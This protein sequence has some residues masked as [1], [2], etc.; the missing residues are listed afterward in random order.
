[1][2]L[3]R[4][5]CAFMAVLCLPVAALDYELGAELS[6]DHSGQENPGILGVSLAGALAGER[7]AGEAVSYWAR[8]LCRGGYSGTGASIGG[9]LEGELSLRK[10]FNVLRLG[11]YGQAAF[12]GT[13]FTWEAEPRLALSMGG[14]SWSAYNEHSF[15]LNSLADGAESYRTELGTALAFPAF[16][17]K[18]A[19]TLALEDLG[20]EPLLKAGARASLSGLA[21]GAL[22]VDIDLGAD[23]T[24]SRGSWSADAGTV[25]SGYLKRSLDWTLETAAWYDSFTAS[26]GLAAQAGISWRFAG[27]L[28]LRA[29]AD[30]TIPLP[31]AAA[32]SWGALVSLSVSGP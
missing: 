11:A 32:L 24:I 18:P 20:A 31:E 8:A 5:A 30:L 29:G 19:L 7:V 1:M 4:A 13:D 12:T 22:G 26:G 3:R 25:L 21:I 10:D 28:I 17:I 23:Y 14:E 15:I 6:W 27:R 2:K 9:E 16:Y